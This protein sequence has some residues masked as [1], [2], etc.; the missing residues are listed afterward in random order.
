MPGTILCEESFGDLAD[1]MA[2]QG[3]RCPGCLRRGIEQWVLQGKHCP[4]CNNVVV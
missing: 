2:L 4:R 3:M 1:S